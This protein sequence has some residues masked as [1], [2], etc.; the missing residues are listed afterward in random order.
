MGDLGGRRGRLISAP[1]RLRAVE[2]IDEAHAGGAR[3][4]MAC[5]EL[6]ISIRTRQ[7]WIRDAA[8]GAVNEDGRKNAVREKP[9]AALNEEERKR[10]LEVADAPEHASRPPAQ[11]VAALADK[12]EWLAS[13]ST[14]YRV[15]RDRGQ[16]HHR[17]RAKSPVPRPPAS[18][19]ATVPN[20]VWTWDITWLK[21][22]VRGK[23][24]YLYMIVDIFSR[25]IVGWEV[26][27]EE[28]GECARELITKAYLKQ[29]LWRSDSPLVLH[30]DNENPHEG[31]HLPS[32]A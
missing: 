5:R 13:E 20:Q 8:A 3:L 22:P 1:D 4:F 27:E 21:S 10:V 15:L 9:A 18:H 14:I 30:S 24:Y 19:S 16:Q 12:G 31:L 32:H 11:I 17:G 2:L 6:G 29:A 28:T 26:H 25:Y 7:R 23:Y